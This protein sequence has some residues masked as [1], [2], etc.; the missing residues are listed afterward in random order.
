[1]LF[2]IDYGVGTDN[3]DFASIVRKSCNYEEGAAASTR[4]RNYVVMIPLA[5]PAPIGHG[6]LVFV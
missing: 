5:L 1:M 6:G 3:G 4:E 2:Y